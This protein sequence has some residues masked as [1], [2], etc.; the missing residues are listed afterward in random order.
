MMAAHAG[1]SPASIES[2]TADT[3]KI[4]TEASLSLRPV[5]AVL[6][7]SAMQSVGPATPPA[8]IDNT[9]RNKAADF[10]AALPIPVLR[11]DQSLT[12]KRV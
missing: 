10:S 2:V 4:R 3:A 12:V 7:L 8:V 5:D 6:F 9:K 1:A 11:T